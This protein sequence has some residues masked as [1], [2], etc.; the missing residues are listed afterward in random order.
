[1]QVKIIVA[2]AVAALGAA[3]PGSRGGCRLG[4]GPGEGPRRRRPPP[5]RAGSAASKDEPAT[6]EEVKALAEELRR[7]KLEMGLRDVEYEL[8]RRDGPGR[9]EGV[10]R[11]EGALH[12]RLRRGLLPEPARTTRPTTR[13]LFRVVLY[14][15]Y[16]F[17]PKILFNAEVEFEHQHELSVEFAYLDFLLTDAVGSG[18]ATCSCRWAS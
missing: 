7:L 4:P 11:A 5:R 18:S 10:L 9:V 8:L 13:D 16:R 6:K 12:R 17:T 2:L 1:M 3:V 14:T 15:G